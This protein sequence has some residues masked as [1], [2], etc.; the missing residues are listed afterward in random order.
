MGCSLAL[1]LRHRQS[2]AAVTKGPLRGACPHPHAHVGQAIPEAAELRETSQVP[3]PHHLLAGGLL[4]A[5]TFLGLGFLL[6]QMG[7][8]IDEVH[9]GVSEAP[10]K[11]A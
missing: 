11:W 10:G 9:A 1:C 4:G 3:Q 8:R 7:I 2:P 5:F 6:L